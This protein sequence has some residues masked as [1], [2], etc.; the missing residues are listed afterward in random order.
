[1]KDA[2]TS[3]AIRTQ[4]EKSACKDDFTS[5]ILYLKILLLTFNTLTVITP[6]HSTNSDRVQ[7][8][9][10]TVIFIKT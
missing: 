6:L 3:K 4:Y 10:Q 9:T 5:F 8:Q 7:G 1:M 2:E